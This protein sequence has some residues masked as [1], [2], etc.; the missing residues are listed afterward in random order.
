MRRR[1][2]KEVERMPY[3]VGVDQVDKVVALRVILPVDRAEHVVFMELP[4]S[5][6]FAPPKNVL[7]NG[8]PYRNLLATQLLA[9]MCGRCVCCDSLLC[10]DNWSCG[11][12]IAE[13]LVEVVHNLRSK[14]RAVERICA[15]VVVRRHLFPFCPISD[16]L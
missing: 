5:Y 3:D 7:V 14:S 4:N 1:I 12:N 6:P 2:D 10:G 9:D 13:L 8:L 11:K 16:F 15:S